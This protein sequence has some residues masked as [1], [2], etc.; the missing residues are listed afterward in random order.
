MANPTVITCENDPTS[1]GYIVLLSDGSERKT[2]DRYEPGA[3][4]E[5]TPPGEDMSVVKPTNVPYGMVNETPPRDPYLDPAI[6]I[7]DDEIQVLKDTVA[8]RERKLQAAND[9][10]AWLTTDNNTLRNDLSGRQRT[11]PVPPG[12]I[13]VTTDKVENLPTIDQLPAHPTMVQ[14]GLAPGIPE[15]QNARDVREHLERKQRTMVEGSRVTED[16]AAHKDQTIGE[17]DAGKIGASGTP[18]GKNVMSPGADTD[19]A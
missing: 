5:P 6:R 2:K 3:E 8:D 13:G 17:V 16:T 1:D 7:K 10:I 4:F 12:L 19:V 9:H 15:D 18:A 14:P 11:A